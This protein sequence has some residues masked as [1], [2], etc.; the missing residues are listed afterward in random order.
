MGHETVES[1]GNMG[2]GDWEGK[3]CLPSLS[4]EEADGL[5]MVTRFNMRSQLTDLGSVV[6]AWHALARPSS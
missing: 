4:E 1:G 6:M 3:R 2:L 5:Y